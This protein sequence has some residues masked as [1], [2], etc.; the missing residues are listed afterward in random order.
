MVVV[1]RPVP[2]FVTATGTVNE[3]V[4]PVRVKPVPACIKLNGENK[5]ADVPMVVTVAVCNHPVPAFVLP[6]STTIRFPGCISEVES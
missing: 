3:M 6:L 2:P 5:I 4:L 1:V